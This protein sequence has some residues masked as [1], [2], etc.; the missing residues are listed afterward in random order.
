MT[1]NSENDQKE[2][3]RGY[4]MEH[5]RILPANTPILG[6]AHEDIIKD[7]GTYVNK[8]QFD[9]KFVQRVQDYIHPQGRLFHLKEVFE[10]WFSRVIDRLHRKLAGK[11]ELD[12]HE[13]V[14]FK[15]RNQLVCLRELGIGNK[16]KYDHYPVINYYATFIV[17]ANGFSADQIRIAEKDPKRWIRRDEREKKLLDE[18]PTG[19]LLEKRKGKE[20]QRSNEYYAKVHE[21]MQ[22]AKEQRQKAEMKK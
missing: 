9:K 11:M 12:P 14:I 21:V 16:A 1:T 4:R 5:P 18:D 13:T 7:P 15:L 17:P 8:F 2:L 19:A 22:K 6:T 3:H 20:R 10:W